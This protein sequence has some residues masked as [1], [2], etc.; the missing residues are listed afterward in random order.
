MNTNNTHEKELSGYPSVDKSWLKYYSE[1]KFDK[2][3]DTKSDML[4]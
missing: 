3:N 4:L 2:T 1:E